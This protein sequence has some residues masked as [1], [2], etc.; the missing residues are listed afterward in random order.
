MSICEL[1]L[2]INKHG[3]VK[4]SNV[5]VGPVWEGDFLWLLILTNENVLS[6]ITLSISPKIFLLVQQTMY[7]LLVTKINMLLSKYKY[8]QHANYVNCMCLD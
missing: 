5:A 3:P 6:L 2:H 1:N 7:L 8:A 4:T